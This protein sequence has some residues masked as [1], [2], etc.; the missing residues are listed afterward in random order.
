ML[1][2]LCFMNT[3]D[4]DNFLLQKIQEIIL[5]NTQAYNLKWNQAHM[6]RFWIC[7]AISYQTLPAKNNL[8]RMSRDAEWSGG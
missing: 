5:K 4:W 2:A 1:K 7:L 8:P 3:L 6:L